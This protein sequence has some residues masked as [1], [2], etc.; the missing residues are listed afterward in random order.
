MFTFYLFLLIRCPVYPVRS[1]ASSF[2]VIEMVSTNLT[3]SECWHEF[4]GRPSSEM[5][6]KKNNSYKIYIIVSPAFS[7]VACYGH[8][9]TRADHLIS[10]LS[11][12]PLRW[13]RSGSVIRD[14]SDHGRS[15]EPMNPLW[16]RT[17]RFIWYTMIRVILLIL[18]KIIP[19]K[20]VTAIGPRPLFTQ[21]RPYRD[22]E[23]HSY[24]ETID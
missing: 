12:V 13:S 1:A 4:T 23:R 15:N 5:Y 21:S 9:I 16:P 10:F 20:L 2:A 22:C 24:Q 18:I 19:K 6:N 7:H 8:F 17:H 3:R 14:H 11:Y